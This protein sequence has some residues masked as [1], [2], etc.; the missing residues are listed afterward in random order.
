MELRAYLKIISKNIWLI[1]VC[2][3]IGAAIAYFIGNRAQSGYRVSQSFLLT[4]SSQKTSPFLQAGQAQPPYDYGRF[5]NQ[6]KSRNFTDTAVAI[7]QNTGFTAPILSGPSSIAAQK[8]APQL[9]KITAVSETASDSKFLLERM[10]VEFNNKLKEFDSSNPLQ[11]TPVDFPQEPVLNRINT[12]VTTTAGL[13]V[14]VAL[15]IFL[16]ALKT[17]FK[18]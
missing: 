8:L 12:S 15:S 18:L 4:E 17:Y 13:L 5:Y 11:L 10:N 1:V 6:E 16:I 2:A 14:G 7:L 3:A 9:I